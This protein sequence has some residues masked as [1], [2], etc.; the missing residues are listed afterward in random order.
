MDMKQWMA[1]FGGFVITLWLAGCNAESNVKKGDKFYAIGEYFEAGAEYRKAYMRTKPKEREKRGER[2]YKAADCYRRINYTARAMG[3]YQNAARY[4]YKDSIVF[5]YLAEMQRKNGDY[6]K[7]AQNYDIYLQY[8][9]DDTLAVNGKLACAMAPIWKDHPN[10]YIVKRA[11]IFNGRRSDYCP[12]LGGDDMEQLYLTS[13]RPQATG[14]DLSGITG[15]K[16]GDIFLSEKDENGNWLQPE[17]IESEI[18]SEYD[19]GA[20]AFSPDGKTMYFTRC[21]Y[22]PEYPRYAQIYTS[23]RSD[24]AWS[25][26]QL[27]EITKDTLSSFAHPTISPD[28]QWLYFVSDMPGGLGGTDIWRIQI[29]EHGMGGVD[30]LGAPI[31]T[32]GNEMFP[33]FRPNGELYFSSDGHVGMGGLD[34]FR[35]VQDSTGTWTVENLQSPMNSPGDDFGM[36]FEGL[37]NRGFFSSNRGDARG[38]DH[39]YSF[40]YPEVL[41]TVKGWVYERDGYELPNAL[42]YMV[43]N[44]GT[45]LKLSVRGDG[46]FTQEINPHV[47]YV[48]L[49][50][51]PG[52]L[53]HKEQ[54]QVDT[55]ST[56]KEYVLQF[57][58]ASLTLPVLVDN[59]FYAFDSAELTDSSTLALDSLVTL[60]EDNPHVTI[61]LSSHC[62]YRGADAYNIALSQ[63]RAESVVNYLITHGIAQDRLTPIGYGESRPKVVRKRLTERYPFLHENDTLTEAFIK[64]LPEDQQEICNALN[65]RTEFRVLRTTYGLYDPEEVARLAAEAA[66]AKKAKEDSVA[67]AVKDSVAKVKQDSIA[68]VRQKAA[69]LKAAQDSL[70]RKNMPVPNRS[71]QAD[72]RRTAPG[73]RDSVNTGTRRPNRPVR[74]QPRTPRPAPNRQQPARSMAN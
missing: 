65:R 32:P 66:A 13:T 5:F 58:L 43:G 44:D 21:T 35:A 55:S 49:G 14:D 2:A 28:G 50:T 7:A 53:N 45:N 41:I 74:R 22:D 61:E 51:C 59:V 40:E 1:F 73:R 12:M 20:C 69:A 39:I 33:S 11:G 54:L 71:P 72:R 63:R 42:V 25:T 62:D 29:G 8:K 24:A 48:F 10:R 70:A 26:P 56:S 3:S 36:T 30:N 9:P 46:S 18:N 64:K 23:E 4:N 27:L 60:M 34:L 68:Q 15:I 57:P 6:K 67:Q 38:W 47:D 31:N 37:H 17:L 52:F 19:E 16:A